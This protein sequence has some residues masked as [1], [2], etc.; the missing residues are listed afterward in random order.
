MEIIDFN[1]FITKR[2]V[3][4]LLFWILF[5]LVGSFIFSYQQN[6]PYS[7]YLLNFL[8]HTPV[9]VLFT[10]G[11]IYYLVPR[12][13]LIRKY[14]QFFISLIFATGISACLRILIARYIYF[15]LF[16]P[17]ILHPEEWISLEIFFLILILVL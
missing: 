5:V 16:I 14:W 2:P 11:V 9:F 17:E 1:R 4:H 8:I 3:I 13:L 7:F 12:F 15:E 10:Y 6:F